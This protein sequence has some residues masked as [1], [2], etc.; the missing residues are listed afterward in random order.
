[1]VRFTGLALVS[2]LL[3]C[4][5]GPRP[6]RCLPTP[7]RSRFPSFPHTTGGLPPIH[8]VSIPIINDD[9]VMPDTSRAGSRAEG[10][11]GSPEP[12]IRAPGG[13]GW[14]RAMESAEFRK[15]RCGAASGDAGL[16][17]IPYMTYQGLKAGG[18]T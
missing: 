8:A 18:G 2:P 6:C 5:P 9:A 1:M 10:G 7:C 4:E 15:W 12:A 11:P 3:A 17:P 16:L 14:G 13:K